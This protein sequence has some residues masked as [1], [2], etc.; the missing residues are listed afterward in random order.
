[1]HICAGCEHP[2]DVPNMCRNIDKHI[3]IEEHFRIYK[4]SHAPAKETYSSNCTVAHNTRPMKIC[5][6][7]GRY[8]FIDASQA[9]MSIYIHV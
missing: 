9:R 1:M 4:N 2:K 5:S 3:K 8:A 7:F 6:T